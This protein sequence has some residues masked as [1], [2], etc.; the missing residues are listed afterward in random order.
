MTDASLH[1]VVASYV[2]VVVSLV[3]QQMG[4]LVRPS[5]VPARPAIVEEVCPA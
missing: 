1:D 2:E 4:P 5:M 3:R